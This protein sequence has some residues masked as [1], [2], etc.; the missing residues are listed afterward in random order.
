[1]KSEGR[2]IDHKMADYLRSIVD[3]SNL[4]QEDWAEKLDVS[5]RMIAYYLSGQRTPSAP[6]LLKIQEVS[7]SF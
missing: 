4:S 1:M 3:K 2:K 7:K 5:P 6:R